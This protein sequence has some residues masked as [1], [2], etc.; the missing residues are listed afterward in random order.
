[1]LQIEKQMK[2]LLNITK[3]TLIVS[4]L[5]VSVFGV[6][7][8]FSKTGAFLTSMVTAA[9]NLIQTGAIDVCTEG[10][11]WLDEVVD[12]HQG[13]RKDG[14]PI[15]DPARTD[16]EAVL[17]VADGQ[18]F[19]LGAGGTLTAK[20]ENPILDQSG[21][22]VDLTV[23]ETTNGRET[24]PE[25]TALIEVSQ[26]GSTWF[27]L[28]VEA[29]SRASGGV[30]EL[31]IASTGLS[32][33]E[34][35]RF[36]DT[37]D[38]GPHAS[39]ADGFD[40]ESVQATY[41]VCDDL[42]LEEKSL[43]G[44]KYH[45]LNGNGQQDDGENGLADWTIYATTKIW[46][47]NVLAQDTPAV[48]TPMLESGVTYIARVTG[49]YNAN[50][51]IEADAMYSFR[52]PSSTEWTDSV[53]TYEGYGPTLLDLQINGTSPAWGDYNADHVYWIPL[54]GADATASFEMYDLDNGANNS[55]HLQLE[56]FEVVEST[57]TDA[58]GNYSLTI[59]GYN[60]QTIYLFEGMQSGWQQTQPGPT[61]YYYQV[62]PEAS[63]TEFDFGNQATQIADELAEVTVCKVDQDQQALNN[64]Q[65]LLHS[66]TAVDSVTVYPSNTLGST[67]GT[68][69][70]IS[71][72]QALPIDDYVVITEGA[73]TYRNSPGATLT[74]ATFSQ[75][76]PSDPVYGGPYA[77]W[78]NVM[79]LGNPG[80]LGVMVNGTPTNWSDI[81]NDEHRYA[82]GYT[83]YTGTFD[84]TIL[85]DI[86]SDNSGQVAVDIYP[87]WSQMTGNNG[88]TTFTD[89]PFGNYTVDEIL[90][91]G[92]D[93]V[94]GTGTVIVDDQTETFTLVN[95]EEA[96]VA[97]ISSLTVSSSPTRDIEE[98]VTNGGFEAGLENWSTSGN[99]TV[100]EGSDHGVMPFQNKMVRIENAH[101]TTLSQDLSNTIEGHGVR[102][103]SFAYN[104]AAY[105]DSL[106]NDQP[107]LMVFAGEQ[108]VYQAWA[109]QIN[110]DGNAETMDATGW[111]TLTIDLTYVE[112]PTLTLAF[113]GRVTSSKPAYVYVD[114]V[115]TNVAV[116]NDQAKF[117][118]MSDGNEPGDQVHYALVRNGVRQEFVGASP[119]E[120]SLT[121]GTDNNQVEYW[122][123]N[124]DGNEEEHKQF[125]V[126]FDNVAPEAP[127]QVKIED[128]GQG[129]GKLSWVA[130]GDDNPFGL[131]QAATYQIKYSSVPIDPNLTKEEWLALPTIEVTQ[132]PLTAG[133]AE[134]LEFT[135][136]GSVTDFYFAIRAKDRAGNY[137]ALSDS[138]MI[139]IA[140]PEAAV[141]LSYD[142]VTH[143]FTFELTEI[144]EYDSYTYELIYDHTVEGGTVGE[145][146][147]GEG[148][149]E[150]ESNQFSSSPLLAGTCSENGEVC[151]PHTN[152]TNASIIV[153]LTGEGVSDKTIGKQ[154]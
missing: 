139:K 73:Y 115:S 2:L 113:Y 118:L 33:I 29:S 147:V 101:I 98:R 53:N 82:R 136:D 141:Q 104:L 41:G 35:I 32:W 30:N 153:T 5:V 80:W 47:S 19:A 128:L 96:P 58:D 154:L 142:E 74:D 120:F 28:P 124:A 107:G 22:D 43:T 71:T 17:G 8:G 12:V 127:G 97:P 106:S 116:V 89:V 36:T 62:A 49:T 9:S 50:D 103:I 21:P 144:E 54:T 110:F 34:Y 114:E 13:L 83:N 146:I 24:Y 86:Y 81:Y 57:V 133:E 137:S 129:Q 138:T 42:P 145:A 75:R 56:L 100:V 93:N 94:S 20:F 76:H 18:F 131:N 99:V 6:F 90:Q 84:F 152:V 15:T 11:K 72:S 87:G 140:P 105:E 149:L 66:P 150:D 95:E 92:W 122:A 52:T 109:S 51:G 79:S 61:A 121:G 3:I 23:N 46:E 55:G 4:L 37:T 123:T 112:D 88:C 67:G 1:M 125:V 130:G 91:V 148:T 135:V 119:L 111:Q 64:W 63:Q 39:N 117:T 102:S 78:V 38:N 31:D 25:E 65:V 68:S 59:V 26:D 45:D 151:V 77:P 134:S 126:Y 85:D 69:N 40:I 108:M 60:D 143:N 16:A 48:V 70:Q 132:P 14:S 27:A 7:G 10:E 44:L